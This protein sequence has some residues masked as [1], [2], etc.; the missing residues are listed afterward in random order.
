L[1]ADFQGAVLRDTV[2]EALAAAGSPADPFLA[3]STRWAARHGLVTLRAARPAFP[4]PPL[5]VM[6]ASIAVQALHAPA[7]RAQ[8][9]R[10]PEVISPAIE[11]R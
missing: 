10:T 7:S 11:D 8:A 5:A 3:A 6:T 1:T 2:A 4:W 9:A